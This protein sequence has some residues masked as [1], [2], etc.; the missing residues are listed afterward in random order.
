MAAG[1]SEPQVETGL[2]NGAS[3][4]IE[5]PAAWNKGVVMYPSTNCVGGIREAPVGLRRFTRME[6]AKWI[7]I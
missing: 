6:S 4:R 7:S 5:V 3:F 1:E 2:L